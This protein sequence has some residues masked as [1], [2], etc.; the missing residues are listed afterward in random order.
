MHPLFFC[1]FA[2]ALCGVLLEVSLT[3]YGEDLPIRP[4][5]RSAAIG[6]AYAMAVGF[7]LLR[8]AVS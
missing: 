7:H 1:A 3:S 6:F 8:F 5:S 4:Q 2:A